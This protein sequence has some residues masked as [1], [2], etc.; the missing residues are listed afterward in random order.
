MQNDPAILRISLFPI[1]TYYGKPPRIPSV[2]IAV[3][4]LLLGETSAESIPPELTPDQAFKRVTDTVQH[5]YYVLDP[6]IGLSVTSVVAPD[7]PE[8]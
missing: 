2:Y 1:A 7:G 6:I 3:F 5:G 4:H 8:L